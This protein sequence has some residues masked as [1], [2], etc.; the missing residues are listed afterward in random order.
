MHLSSEEI[1]GRLQAGAHAR[2][3]EYPGAN[4]QGISARVALARANTD[5][6]SRGDDAVRDYEAWRANELR[7]EVGWHAQYL[8]DR[9]LWSAAEPI[10]IA[11]WEE[12]EPAW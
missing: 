3:A 8:A 7:P 5:E 10:P 9:A 4:T 12:R 6:Q 11:S 1:E 2:W